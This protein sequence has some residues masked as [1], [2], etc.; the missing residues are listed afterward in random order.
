MAYISRTSLWTASKIHG[1]WL[2]YSLE[3]MKPV[4][5]TYSLLH[6]WRVIELLGW[7]ISSNVKNEVRKEQKGEAFYCQFL[8]EGNLI[9]ASKSVFL[10]FSG[11]K[12][13]FKYQGCHFFYLYSC[14]IRHIRAPFM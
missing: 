1:P 14:I 3:Q 9:Q 7:L 5:T 2:F 8:L 4:L 11:I 13:L 6:Q 12:T 10:A